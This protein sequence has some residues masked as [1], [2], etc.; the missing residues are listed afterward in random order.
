[1]VSYIPTPPMPQNPKTPKPRIKEKTF[2]NIL[3]LDYKS[4]FKPEKDK[5]KK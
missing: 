2:R 1:M 3:I 4:I 5:R